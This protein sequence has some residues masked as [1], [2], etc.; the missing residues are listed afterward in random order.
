MYSIQGLWSAAELALPV[1]FVIVNNRSYRAL[2]EFAPHFGL[3]IPPGTL[4][5]PS[6][7]NASCDNLRPVVG[8]AE[9]IDQSAGRRKPEEPGTRLPGL[10][11]RR[12]GANFN[13][14]EPE[15][16]QAVHGSRILIK[17]GRQTHAVREVQTHTFDRDNRGPTKH[18]PAP[19]P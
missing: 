9:A 13:E 19:E 4:L 18:T 6:S 10:G 17:A 3:A 11:T 8:E 15:G 5:P 14:A 1:A 2:N 12:H 16:A 7:S